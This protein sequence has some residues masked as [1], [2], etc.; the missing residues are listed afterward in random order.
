MWQHQNN[1]FNAWFDYLIYSSL[2]AQ[3]LPLMLYTSYDDYFKNVC[4]NG[5]KTNKKV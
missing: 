1:Y 5:V 4:L 3:Y 2:V